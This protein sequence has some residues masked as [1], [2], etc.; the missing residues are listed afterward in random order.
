MNFHI[1]LSANLSF[2]VYQRIDKKAQENAVCAYEEEF[3]K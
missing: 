3:M 2:N 1:E